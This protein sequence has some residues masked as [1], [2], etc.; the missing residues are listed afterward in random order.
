MAEFNVP[1]PDGYIFDRDEANEHECFLEQNVIVY[2]FIAGPKQQTAPAASSPPAGSSAS[3]S[4]TSSHNVMTK[5]MRRPW[6]EVERFLVAHPHRLSTVAP[7]HR[8]NSHCGDRA[9]ARP[10]AG[11]L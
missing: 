4:S 5:K 3:S 1:A 6:E 8:R 10:F 2:A 11:L 7:L 9:G